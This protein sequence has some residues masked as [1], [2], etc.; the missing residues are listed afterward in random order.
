MIALA[1][2]CSLEGGSGNQLWV[3]LPYYYISM[4]RGVAMLAIPIQV[5]WDS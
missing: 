4:N 3:R 5:L 2:L 1:F